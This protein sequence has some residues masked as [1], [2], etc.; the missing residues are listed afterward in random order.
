MDKDGNLVDDF[1]FD[2]GKTKN[3][4]DLNQTQFLLTCNYKRRGHIRKKNV[5]CKKR[6]LTRCHILTSNRECYRRR[7][8]ES[9]RITKTKKQLNK[10]HNLI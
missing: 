5:T 4:I 8:R 1:V 6:T 3:N 9:F 2:T 10:S 7:G